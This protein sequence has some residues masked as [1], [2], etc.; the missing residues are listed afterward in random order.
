MDYTPGI[1]GMQTPAPGGIETTWAKQLAL[2]VVIYSLLQM[3][4]DLLAN[5]EANPGS[6]S[7]SRTCRWTGRPRA[8]SKARSATS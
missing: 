4:A 1:F 5:Y 7:S 8:C 2:Y 6:S 3:A